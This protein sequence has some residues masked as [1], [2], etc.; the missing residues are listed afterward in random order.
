MYLHCYKLEVSTVVRYIFHIWISYPLIVG[1]DLSENIEK[2]NRNH[3]KYADCVI[4][5][6]TALDYIQYISPL[7]V[8]K[9]FV[10]GKSYEIYK[11]A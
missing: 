1:F 9:M 11:L 4:L 3:L 7:I 8:L 6:T 5:K 10:N 2:I